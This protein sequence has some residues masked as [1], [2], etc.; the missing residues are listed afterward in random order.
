MTA[1]DVQA[2]AE[3][4]TAVTAAGAVIT[5]AWRGS[6]RWLKWRK[7]KRRDQV[8]NYVVP[9]CALTLVLAV[10]LLGRRDGGAR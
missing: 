6:H 7:Q 5:W 3:S 1:P 2:I 10:I 9:A 4:V 8:L